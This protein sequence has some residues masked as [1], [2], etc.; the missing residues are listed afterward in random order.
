MT[1]RPKESERV[2]GLAFVE[3]MLSLPLAR[4]INTRR[5]LPFKPAVYIVYTQVL[6]VLYVG[7]T[8]SLRQR[9]TQDHHRGYLMD[10]PNCRIAWFPIHSNKLESWVIEFLKPPFNPLQM[11]GPTRWD[12]RIGFEDLFSRD[13]LR[14]IE[15]AAAEQKAKNQGVCPW[16]DG[17][18]INPR[19]RRQEWRAAP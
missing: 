4:D 10:V 19:F 7:A 8:K 3:H 9:W 13:D 2:K 11:K 5:C 15:Q 16:P 18:Y 6:G 12:D 14:R 1:W 17:S